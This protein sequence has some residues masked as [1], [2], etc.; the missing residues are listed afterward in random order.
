MYGE[1]EE[2]KIRC[3]EHNWKDIVLEAFVRGTLVNSAKAR[4]DDHGQPSVNSVPAAH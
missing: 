2:E 3:K 4:Q 1:E